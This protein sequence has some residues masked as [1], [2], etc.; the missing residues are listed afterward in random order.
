MCRHVDHSG[1][2]EQAV[3]SAHGNGAKRILVDVHPDRPVARGFMLPT[4]H[5]PMNPVRMLKAL[6]L[7]VNSAITNADLIPES[8]FFRI[9]HL[10]N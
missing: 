9:P 5:L 6:L 4:G 8:C 1:G 10:M 7:D 2:L 3:I